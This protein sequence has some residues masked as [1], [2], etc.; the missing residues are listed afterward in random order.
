MLLSPKT[1]ARKLGHATTTPVQRRLSQKI[2]KANASND[3]GVGADQSSG[4]GGSNSSSSSS[5]ASMFTGGRLVAAPAGK[6]RDDAGIQEGPSPIPN[7]MDSF[8]IKKTRSL[9][10]KYGAKAVKKHA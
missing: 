2:I 10:G 3:T 7:M 1:A 8:V 5:A 6:S 4:S 9:P